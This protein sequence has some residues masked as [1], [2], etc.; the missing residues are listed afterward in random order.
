MSDH[1]RE[2]FSVPVFFLLKLFQRSFS[3]AKQQSV[4]YAVQIL[5]LLKENLWFE[6]L[7]CINIVYLTSCKQKNNCYCKLC[8]HSALLTVVVGYGLGSA[9]GGELGSGS[10][11]RCQSGPNW[12][13]W[14]RS[15][16]YVLSFIVACWTRRGKLTDTDETLRDADEKSKKK[17]LESLHVILVES[18]F[19]YLQQQIITDEEI[20]ISKLLYTEYTIKNIKMYIKSNK[21][22]YLCPSSP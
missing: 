9:A 20:Q 18:T 13:R 22:T 10:R 1:W 12:H 5:K 16:D 2:I 15:T 11:E 3:L 17:K 6:I 7:D 21:Q 14:H 4:S 8:L 19:Y